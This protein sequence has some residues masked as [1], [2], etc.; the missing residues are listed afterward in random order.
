[1]LLD[2]FLDGF[3]YVIWMPLQGILLHGLGECFVDGDEA[4]YRP[5]FLSILTGCQAYMPLQEFCGL[6]SKTSLRA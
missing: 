2:D 4:G 5:P 6:S 3:L 1:M